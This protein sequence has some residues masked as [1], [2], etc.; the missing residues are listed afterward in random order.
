MEDEKDSIRQECI[1]CIE[2]NEKTVPF[3]VTRSLDKSSKVRAEVY[4]VLKASET[5]TFFDIN[6]VDRI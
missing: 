3:I 5:M 2:L 6:V 1:S 4:K